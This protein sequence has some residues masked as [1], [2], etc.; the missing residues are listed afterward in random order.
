KGYQFSMNDY[1][2]YCAA[3]QDLL[4]S[5]QQCVA[6]LQGG[7]VAHLAEDFL[8][9]KDVGHGP[10]DDVLQ[11]GYCQKSSE[12]PSLGYWDDELTSKELDLISG[13][14]RVDSDIGLSGPQTSD[15]SWWPKHP[16]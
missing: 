10:S 14:Y 16:A 13:V 12:D 11:F 5:P 4:R 15:I 9:V 8:T 1:H 3:L 7:I 6:M 2:L